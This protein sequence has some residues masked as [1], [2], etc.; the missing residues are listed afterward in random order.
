MVERAPDD[1]AND[2]EYG[3]D[4]LYEDQKSASS[5]SRGFDN[6]PEFDSFN[7]DKAEDEQA[8]ESAAAAERILMEV[9]IPPQEPDEPFGKPEQARV[10]LRRQMKAE[11][12][13]RFEESAQTEADFRAVIATW[14]R[15]DRNRERRERYH[16][17]LRDDSIPL[18]Y[19]RNEQGMIFP[20]WYMNP[21]IQQLSRGNFLDYLSDCPYEMHDLTAKPYLRKIIMDMKEEH[22]EVFYFLFL[23]QY[24]AL[25]LAAIRGQTDRNI[26][27]VRDTALRKIR[28]KVFREL[29]KRRNLTTQE[30][31]F[32]IGYK[33]EGN[34]T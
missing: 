29:E 23:R 30:R 14:D 21:T 25:R 12:L 2:Y 18:E 9:N 24:G 28:K 4:Y 5:D 17:I 6:V 32:L 7:D 16:E 10:S 15:L 26:R 31:D 3:Y 11:A 27:K 8:I 22:K 34:D 13:K 20:M 1:Q 33:A 19:G